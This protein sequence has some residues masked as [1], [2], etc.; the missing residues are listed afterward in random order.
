MPTLDDVRAQPVAVKTL[1]TAVQR[2]RVASS[3][4]FEGP[5]GVGK[6]RAA[7]GLASA[8]LCPAA[9]GKGCGSCD[10]CGRIARG[11]H[12]DV[13]VFLPR[14]EG[15]RNIQVEFIR[16]EVLPFSQ[17]APFEGAAALAIFPDADISFPDNHAEAANAMLKTLEEPRARV[18]FVLLA[19]RPDQLLQTIRSRCQRVRF[20]RLPDRTLRQ[21]L[22]ERG[23]PETER[24]AAVALADGRADLALKLAA[25]GTG[26]KLLDLA[27]RIDQVVESGRAGLQ[28]EL[29]EELA[30][31]DDRELVL[32][33]LAMLY[34]DIAA[35]AAGLG[36]DALHFRPEAAQIRARAQGL[37]ASRAAARAELIRDAVAAIDTN[38]NPQ[39][40]LD[41][42]LFAL[43]S[44]A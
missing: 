11:N 13:R 32:D 12:P 19:S 25:D 40:M 35:S 42:L 15:D 7:L 20:Q 5:S 22:E 4:L 6:Q 41:S 34:R 10:V 37:G 33:T 16:A 8:L 27:L 28:L 24:D 1:R 9:P 23:V 18:H 43:R 29:A 38:G 30:R 17:F 44:A 2:D 36:D 26:R 3:Y 21:L 31:H 14:E 39:L